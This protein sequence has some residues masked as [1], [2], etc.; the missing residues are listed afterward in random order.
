[1]SFPWN[2]LR[3]D[4]LTEFEVCSNGGNVNYGDIFISFCDYLYRLFIH[5]LSFDHLWLLLLYLIFFL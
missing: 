3:G 5:S 4:G 2:F 1:M